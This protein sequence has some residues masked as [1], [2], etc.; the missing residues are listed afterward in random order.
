MG[1][2]RIFFDPNYEVAVIRAPGRP[3]VRQQVRDESAAAEFARQSGFGLSGDEWTCLHLPHR[4]AGWFTAPLATCIDMR[5]S[6][7]AA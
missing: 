1:H 7:V 6:C 4:W 5:A 3:A 2:A